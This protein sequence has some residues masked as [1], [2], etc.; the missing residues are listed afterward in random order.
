[1]KTKH[2]KKR[3]T[4]FIYEALVREMAKAMVRRDTEKKDQVSAV[5]QEHF[6]KG[7]TLDKELQCYR[8]LHEESGVD[9]YTAEKIIHRAKQQY[10]SLDKKQI[11]KEQSA[12]IGKINKTLGSGLFSNF[13]PNYRTFATISQIFS[14]KTPVKQKVLM[15]RQI[16][17]IISKEAQTEEEVVPVDNLVVK[18]FSQRYNEQYQHLLPEQKTLL[19][20]YILAF[21]DNDADFR[22]A[23]AEELHRIYAAIETSL[24][25]PE[26]SSDEVM[27][28]NTKKVMEEVK[29]FSV[30]TIGEKELRKILKLQ[31]L[32]NEYSHDAAND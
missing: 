6:K 8:A 19:T 11:F 18:S 12:V 30:A 27:L 31:N 20:K 13:V 15:E 16:L 5:M 14:D 17:K 2:N 7:T 22:V 10:D 21:G 28:E 23:I 24:K 32:V 4:A 9:N 1:M 25:L 26:V 3:N 29:S